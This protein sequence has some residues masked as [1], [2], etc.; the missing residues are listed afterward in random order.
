MLLILQSFFDGNMKVKVI[1]RCHQMK[2]KADY[3]LKGGC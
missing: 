3:H 1:L 2:N